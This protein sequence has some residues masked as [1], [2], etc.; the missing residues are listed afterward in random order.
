MSIRRSALVTVVGLVVIVAM[1]ALAVF[2]TFHAGSI[3]TYNPEGPDPTTTEANPWVL[4]T[5]YASVS[6]LAGAW[7]WLLA[8]GLKDGDESKP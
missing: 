7:L 8:H 6:A 4:V 3:T 2:M 1:L 5:I